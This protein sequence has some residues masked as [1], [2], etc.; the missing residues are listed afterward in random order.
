MFSTAL[1]VTVYVYVD[2]NSDNVNS[3]YI[4]GGNQITGT[5]SLQFDI[6]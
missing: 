4:N 1:E 2:G 6:D 3:N 5:L